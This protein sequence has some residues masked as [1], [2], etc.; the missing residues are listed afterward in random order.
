LHREPNIISEIRILRSLGR[1]KR[2]PEERNVKNKVLSN[3]PEGKGFFG[4]PRKR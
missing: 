1:V 4:K 2:M 3:A